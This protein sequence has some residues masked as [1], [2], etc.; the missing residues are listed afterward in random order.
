[1][2]TV[3]YTM[4][5]LNKEKQFTI[6]ADGYPLFFPKSGVKIDGTLCPSPKE[7]AW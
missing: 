5:V 6:L 4:K 3:N 7:N 2:S 1:M